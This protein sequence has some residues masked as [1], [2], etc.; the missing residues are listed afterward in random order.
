MRS[1]VRRQ[2]GVI[3]IYYSINR[4]STYIPYSMVLRFK[5]ER[6]LLASFV[7]NFILYICQT[8]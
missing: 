6:R 7:I 3:M 2:K 1:R 4:S 8:Q 5:M